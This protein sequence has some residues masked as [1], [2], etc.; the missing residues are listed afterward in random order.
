MVQ[1][2]I[3]CVMVSSRRIWQSGLLH[4]GHI[5]EFPLGTSEVAEVSYDHSMVPVVMVVNKL[6]YIL[7][8]IKKRIASDSHTLSFPVVQSYF[9][10]VVQ[11]NLS[12]VGLPTSSN[13]D[14]LQ[15]YHTVTMSQRG[16]YQNFRIN[17]AT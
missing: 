4:E 17:I 15:K 7:C 1:M 12:P 13:L 6:M 14:L 10:D 3:C 11:K 9:S 16:S 5:W 8:E 2:A